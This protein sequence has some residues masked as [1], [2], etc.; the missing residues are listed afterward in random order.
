MSEFMP[1]TLLPATSE[2]PRVPT[3][4]QS[5]G[6]SGRAQFRSVVQLG[7][8]WNESWPDLRLGKAD[9]EQ[10]L[11]WL[12][13]A[14]GQQVIFEVTHPGLCG[15]GKAARGA[16]GGYP[17][18]NGA[19]QTGD[20]LLTAGWPASTTSVMAAGDVFRIT[21]VANLFRVR[22]DASSDASGLATVQIDPPI[23]SG[24]SPTH[25]AGIVNVG[26]S[27]RAA[28]WDYTQ[29]P[30]RPGQFISG[31][32]ATLRELPA[33]VQAASPTLTRAATATYVDETGTVQTAAS[34]VL[35]TNHWVKTTDGLWLPTTL[36]ERAYTNLVGSDD[37]STWVG[38][39]PAG[40]TA[41]SAIGGLAAWTLT[42]SDVA[43]TMNR[44]F[45]VTFATDG[46][47]SYSFFFRQG[48]SDASAV[49][50]YDSTAANNLGN[51]TIT[52]SGGIP[53][54]V[55]A[56]GSLLSLQAVSGGWLAHILVTGVVAAHTNQIQFI[57]AV[58]GAS[59]TGSI[60]I[61]RVNVFDDP[62]P[63]ASIFAAS[64]TRPAD[65]LQAPAAFAPGSGF[66]LYAKLICYELGGYGWK[67]IVGL[68][69]N[70]A[71]G[72]SILVLATSTGGSWYVQR[73]SSATAIATASLGP[74]PA[75]GQ[76]FELRLNV[77]PSGTITVGI[78]QDGGPET[79][80]SLPNVTWD[81]QWN[82]QTLVI[83]NGAGTHGN[84]GLLS[85]KIDSDPTLTLDQLRALARPDLVL[86]P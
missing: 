60:D 1:R 78:S 57:P 40:A 35:R 4:L 36:V 80:V 55:V 26:C 20:E 73:Q 66:T 70:F 54:L 43:V 12:E 37:L 3:G 46:V 19:N 34:G 85:V 52:W 33:S 69:G 67:A 17:V 9:V 75:Y 15:S 77:P 76:P 72:S 28:V 10:L 30:G 79:T 32:K 51:V 56:N 41:A 44:I 59:A 49:K 2:I 62:V 14:Y 6:V 45:T 22:A 42:D 39:G 29:P 71:S 81:P 58:A 16:G 7:R 61:G 21:G 63:P 74:A 83:G 24:A 82:P 38:V 65:V 64:E 13:W 53:S 84:V 27:I 8:V 23:P 25:G 86:Y 5:L 68:G 18:V 11:A 48:T 47:K 50:L 31:L